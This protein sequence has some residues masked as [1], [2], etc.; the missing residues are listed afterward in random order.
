ML[1]DEIRAKALSIYDLLI[2]IWLTMGEERQLAFLLFASGFLGAVISILRIRRE[3]KDAAR[4]KKEAKALAEQ[5]VEVEQEALQEVEQELAP[6]PTQVKP[7]TE[8]HK[9]EPR[10]KDAASE[11][12]ELQE[13][14]SAAEVEIEQPELEPAKAQP[15]PEP[16]ADSNFFSGLK[17]TRRAFGAKLQAIF[18]GSAEKKEIFEQLEGALNYQ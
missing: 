6:E 2:S 3:A 13:E 10:A 7:L 4:L 1:M 11:V 8:E 12:S 17:K 18:G 9:E 16:S 14:P 15:L 5:Q